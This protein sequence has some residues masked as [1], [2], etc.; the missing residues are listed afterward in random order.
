M[1]RLHISDQVYHRESPWDHKAFASQS[2]PASLCGSKD[3]H[4][5]RRGDGL[6]M[7][8]YQSVTADVHCP[9]CVDLCRLMGSEPKLEPEPETLPDLEL[10]SYP[11]SNLVMFKMVTEAAREFVKE[12]IH[13]PMYLGSRLAVESRYAVGLADGMR[14]AGL[15]IGVPS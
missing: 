3:G 9:A 13:E 15:T 5:I 12:H 11:G 1:T 6:G 2:S 4:V 14:D 7:L 10:E 8:S